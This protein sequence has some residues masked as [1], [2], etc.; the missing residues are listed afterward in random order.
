MGRLKL[1]MAILAF[2]CHKSGRNW[3]LLVKKCH[4]GFGSNF[5]VK[6]SGG[7]FSVIDGHTLDK[8]LFGCN[9][10]WAA[11]ELTV[12][13]HVRPTGWAFWYF[14]CSAKVHFDIA[15]WT[16]EYIWCFDF[17]NFYSQCLWLFLFNEL[18]CDNGVELFR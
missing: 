10:G 8:K 5:K 6:W 4:V 18:C 11:A 15:D 3:F 17:Q 1:P 12:N 16:F 7:F 13:F 9:D 14:C 2:A